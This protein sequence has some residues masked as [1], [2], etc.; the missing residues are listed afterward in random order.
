MS[1]RF[2]YDDFYFLPEP[3][4]LIYSHY[5]EEPVWQLLNPA[6]SKSDFELYP[7]VKSFFFIAGMQFLQQ[8]R[9]VLYTKRGIVTVTLGFTR[10]TAFTHKIGYG[11]SAIETVQVSESRVTYL[12]SDLH[13]RMRGI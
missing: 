7:L 2:R 1:R 6:R 11:E 12:C 5:P 3:S 4:M 10:P 13:T 9:G 8:N